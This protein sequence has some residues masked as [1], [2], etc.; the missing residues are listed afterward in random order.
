MNI[1]F[2]KILSF[3]LYFWRE[4]LL[5]VIFVF[6]F[7]FLL[8]PYKTALFVSWMLYV[9]GFILLIILWK[10]ELK[11][12]RC[13]LNQKEI[14]ENEGMPIFLGDDEI[15]E[16][17]QDKLGILEDAKSFA[18]QVLNN[19][20]KN[21]II[22]GLDAPWGSGKSSYLN[23]CE[24]LIWNQQKDK[25]LVFRFKPMIFDASKQDL[26]VIFIEE[27]IKTLNNNK[28]NLGKLDSDFKKLMKIFKGFSISG[29]NF[30]FSGVSDSVSDLLGKI[31]KHSKLLDKKIIIIIDD[32][33]R[34]YLEDI[35]AILGVI[36]NIFYTDK[37][38]F[39]LC[40]DSNSINTF[41]TKYKISNRI[42]YKNDKGHTGKMCEVDSHAVSR[43][44]LDNR[45][46]NA[47][48]EK[49]VQVKKSLI[50][51]RV[52][53][54][55]LL[56]DLV[57]INQNEIQNPHLEKLI[58]GIEELFSPN[59]F[60]RY[61]PLLGDVRKVKRI[62]NFLRSGNPK[63]SIA[64]ID[65]AERDIKPIYLL[66]LILIYINFPAIFQKIYVSETGGA[67]GFFSA[68]YKFLSTDDNDRYTNSEQFSDY[69]KT[70]S[71]E[72]AFLLHELFCVECAK[73]GCKRKI[74]SND[75]NL[76]S[77]VDDDFIK[78]SPMFNGS[79]GLEANNNLADYLRIIYEHRLLPKS[80]Y[81][82]FHR[83]RVKEL[84]FKSVEEIFKDTEEYDVVHG[85]NPREQFFAATQTKEIPIASANKAIRYILDNINH[86]SML[87]GF[88]SIYDGLRNDLVYRLIW[89]LEL[90]GWADEDGKSFGNT[91][92][93]VAVI[94]E[95][96]MKNDSVVGMPIADKLLDIN[97]DPVLTLIDFTKFIYASI[98]SDSTFNLRRSIV[99]YNAKEKV[100]IRE[101]LSHK[102]FTFFEEQF[103][104]KGKNFLKE[105][106]DM[107]EGILLGDFSEFI[108]NKFKKE[109]KSLED[110][111]NKIKTNIVGGLIYR[112]GSEEA[113]SL[114]SY[115]YKA[116]SPDTKIYNIMRDYLFDVCFNIDLDISN[117]QLFMNYVL[118]S[119]N[120]DI[121]RHTREWR[122]SVVSLSKTLGKDSLKKY[123]M[124]NHE[125]IKE[126][127]RKLPADTKVFTSNYW[128]SYKEDLEDAF[129]ELDKNL[130]DQQNG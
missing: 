75:F 63:E 115:I 97:H 127:C 8:N 32:L 15:V 9:V 44:H 53:L 85:E 98:G 74:W 50:P 57:K 22:F 105:V 40:Y 46:I 90:R 99:S 72:E 16:E 54:M 128:V 18:E 17:G 3:I 107:S 36:R 43:E 68:T 122:P 129:N 126:Y 7:F 6:A 100:D 51:S 34:L 5:S 64:E 71:D 12:R 47:Y 28:I 27:F 109:D 59:N 58:S 84:E 69:L 4:S 35:K 10:N 67:K 62:A 1:Y 79:L 45:M 106:R 119:F 33:D 120:H 61:Q 96:I 113:E 88:N 76:A 89:I 19:N 103:I 92:E 104:N 60:W 125:K 30:D 86:Y 114:A 25:V 111:I 118:S 82:S 23:L 130:L 39:I 93:N 117:S 65:F 26:A 21:P 37:I 108:S 14:S 56:I 87:D 13:L 124:N 42:S 20:S 49:F 123:W 83:N 95:R 55:N 70:L 94:A 80:S 77:L 81:Y 78:M 29:F 38:T 24:K 102:A 41:E 66:R 73:G 91:D 31:K 48:L 116:D 110:E 121:A 52:Q 101:I 112:F 11:K 2:K